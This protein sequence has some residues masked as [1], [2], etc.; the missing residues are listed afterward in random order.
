MPTTMNGQRDQDSAV[1]SV[2]ISVLLISVFTIAA[3]VFFV[4]ILPVVQDSRAN[5]ESLTIDAT[6]PY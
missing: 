1:I 3:I 4:Y 5:S 6:L 2:A